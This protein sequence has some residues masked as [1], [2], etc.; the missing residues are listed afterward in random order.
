MAPERFGNL[1]GETLIGRYQIQQQLGKSAGRR[2]LLALD[3][4]TQK[5]VVIKLLLFGNDFE[6]D[7][8]K[9][10]EREAKTLQTLS[11][12]AIPRYLNHFELDT[13]YGKGFALVQTYIEAKA[14]SDHLKAGRSFSEEDVKQLAIAMLEILIYLHER[15]P[16]VIHRD[17]KPSN[18]LLADRTGNS[19]GQ[20]YL[21]D[22]GS[23][24]T[25][26]AHEGGT[27]TVV[28]TYGYMP[29]E[30]FGGR[31]VPASDL[32]SLG[33]TLIYTI[34]GQHPADL[35]QNNLRLQFE[36][37]VTLRPAFVQWLKR[38]V[39]PSLDRRFSSARQAL[40]A[41]KQQGLQEESGLIVQQPAGSKVSLH[42]DNDALDILLPPT[43]L[44]HRTGRQVPVLFAIAWN[45]FIIFWTFNVL[46]AGF[47][48][49]LFFGLFS[50]P[51][52]GVGIR[53]VGGILAALFQTTRLRIDARQIS[54]THEAFGLK[55]H[56]LPPS[57][58]QDITKLEYRRRSSS[59]D[60]AGDRYETP[61][62]L[63]IWAGVRMYELSDYRLSDPEIE[64]LA[65][66]L[67]EWLGLPLSREEDS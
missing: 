41:L 7:D 22:F 46:S 20:V 25:L 8:L 52:W 62:K 17:I 60:V 67:S 29:P 2:T 51:F 24:Q 66:E 59:K 36:Q 40:T 63:R 26:A 9:L 10:F 37:T 53:M 48:I 31:S 55:R 34:T 32:Y 64:W 56:A 58:R 54:L 33:A 47:P 28:G 27:I 43:G 3:L 30:Q 5:P 19:I 42:K 11:H 65:H 38:M 45:S 4:E 57:R 13:P 21:V 16:P 49:N 18:I 61:P 15:Q 1:T 6:W 44:N 35:P 23:V 14:L 12:P 39:E 50:L